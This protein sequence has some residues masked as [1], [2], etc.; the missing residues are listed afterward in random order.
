MMECT[1][2]QDIL[3]QCLGM[4]DVQRHT[5]LD[6]KRVQDILKRL[7]WTAFKNPVRLSGFNSP[8]RAWFKATP[9]P[10]PEPTQMPIPEL[11]PVAVHPTNPEPVSKTEF[12]A[13]PVT[14]D[15]G[16][17]ESDEV[18]PEYDRRSFDTEEEEEDDSVYDY[19]EPDRELV[20]GAV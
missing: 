16:V 1:R 9:E 7:G 2:I 11:I 12:S 3:I 5:N 13:Q 6:K 18:Y 8:Q 14:L 4:S 19:S 10:T 17:W 15:L 20:G